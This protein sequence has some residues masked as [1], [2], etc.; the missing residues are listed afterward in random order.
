M[1]RRVGRFVAAIAFLVVTKWLCGLALQSVSWPN[2]LLIAHWA[3]T[4]VQHRFDIP[5]STVVAVVKF[6]VEW[7]PSLVLL[8]VIEPFITHKLDSR[9]RKN[10]TSPPTER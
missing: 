6:L 9:A 7:G 2:D 10:P 3:E 4:T 1:L 5:A 8:W